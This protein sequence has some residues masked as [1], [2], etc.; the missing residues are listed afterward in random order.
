MCLAAQ[1][2]SSE[3]A[4]ELRANVKRPEDS[5]IY[6][7]G[8]PEKRV[9]VEYKGQNIV[10]QQ[11]DTTSSFKRLYQATWNLLDTM[12][13]TTSELQRFTMAMV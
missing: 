2:L 9:R 13:P 8:C 5:D 4:I 3:Q 6:K 11:A 7:G 1:Q 12:L 10:Y